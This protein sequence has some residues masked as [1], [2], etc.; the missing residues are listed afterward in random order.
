VR[1]VALEKWSNKFEDKVALRDAINA[2]STHQLDPYKK[3]EAERWLLGELMDSRELS[4]LGLS[5]DLKH[6]SH[7]FLMLKILIENSKSENVLFI[8]DF[9]KIISLMKP[10]REFI[11]IFEPSWLYGNEKSSPDYI[12]A[13]KTLEKILKL[14]KIKGLRIIITLKSIDSLEEIKKIVK[15]KNKKLLLNFKKPLFI[16]NFAESDIYQFYKKN[17]EQFLK[18]INYFE[19]LD[20]FPDAYFPINKKV[21]KYIFNRTQGNPR[22]ITKFLIKIFNEIIYSDTKVENIIEKYENIR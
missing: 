2:I 15:K 7:S 6:E 18:T 9:E 14:Q 3:I 17:I 10:D 8:D 12:A 5:S 22:E 16:S 11:E 13:Q 1:K 19:Y 21:L 20:E 4:Y